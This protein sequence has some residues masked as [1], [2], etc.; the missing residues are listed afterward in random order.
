MAKL[1]VAKLNFSSGD[2]E[3]AAEADVNDAVTFVECSNFILYDGTI[4]TAALRYESGTSYLDVWKFNGTTLIKYCEIA[5]WDAEIENCI[6]IGISSIEGRFFLTY[7]LKPAGASF[8]FGLKEFTGGTV[9]N[10]EAF[11]DDPTSVHANNRIW[12][13]DIMP[14]GTSVREVHK[15]EV[16]KSS[17]VHLLDPDETYFLEV[18]TV[19]LHAGASL[20]TF[21]INTNNWSYLS[22]VFTGDW[23][24]L[25]SDDEWFHLTGGFYQLPEQEYWVAISQDDGTATYDAQILDQELAL[26]R[27]LGVSASRLSLSKSGTKDVVAAQIN[28]DQMKLYVEGDEKA[29]FGDTDPEDLNWKPHLL[30]Q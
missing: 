10:I 27:N 9:L 6:F 25:D 14:G 7:N 15:L 19:I 20:W 1:A 16:M 2:W 8:E 29:A 26:V 22:T 28:A 13:L 3:I 11:A 4:Y 12:P 5:Y 21:N 24:N 30:V 18:T 23:D 17:G